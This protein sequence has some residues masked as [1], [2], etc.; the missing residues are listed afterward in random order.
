M[1]ALFMTIRIGM[2]GFL[3]PDF[4]VLLIKFKKL[5]IKNTYDELYSL[6]K[7]IDKLT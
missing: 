1:G 2:F 5:N 7:L 4:K 3:K 6:K